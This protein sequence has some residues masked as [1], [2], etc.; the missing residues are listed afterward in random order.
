MRSTRVVPGVQSCPIT[1]GR[2]WDL[3]PP[4]DLF[5]ARSRQTPLFCQPRDW[6]GPNALKELRAIDPDLLSVRV[7]G[8]DPHGARNRRRGCFTGLRYLNAELL[9]DLSRSRRSELIETL[10]IIG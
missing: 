10:L 3:H 7:P 5:Q 8:A 6:L 4:A 1:A 2:D 9:E